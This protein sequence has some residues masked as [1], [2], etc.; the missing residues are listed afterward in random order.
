MAADDTLLRM[1]RTRRRSAAPSIR[2]FRPRS[3]MGS[4]VAKFTIT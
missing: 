4:G 2:P 1:T 3:V